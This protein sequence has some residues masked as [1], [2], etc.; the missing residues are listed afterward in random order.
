MLVR[1]TTPETR[2]KAYGYF[3]AFFSLG[4][5]AGS[6]S[7]GL[8]DKSLTTLFT[9]TAFVLFSCVALTIILSRVQ[10]ESNPASA[11]K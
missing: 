3:Y 11:V 2:G 8:L 5:V 1:A 10:G 7:L 9:I 6:F 4:V